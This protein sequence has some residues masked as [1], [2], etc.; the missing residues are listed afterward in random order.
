MKILSLDLA[1]K[2]GWAHSDGPSGVWDFKIKRD[3]SGGMRLIRLRSKIQEI[4]DKAGFTLLVYEATRHAAP[5]MQGA[6]VVQAEL[7]S[8]VKVFCEIEKIEYVGKSPKEIKKHATG[9]GN[10]NKEKMLAAAEEKWP[11]KN[12]EDHNESDA[13]WLLNLIQF[14]LGEIT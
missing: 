5:G 6:L 2:T 11:H 14:E 1:T 9:S 4:H 3:E 12:I 13:L 7:Q 10:A 8:V